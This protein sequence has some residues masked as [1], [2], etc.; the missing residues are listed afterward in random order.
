MGC[1]IVTT[2]DDKLLKF[3]KKK[4][5]PGAKSKD[6]LIESNKLFLVLAYLQ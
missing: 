1:D 4:P 3:G 6:R 5:H 2:E